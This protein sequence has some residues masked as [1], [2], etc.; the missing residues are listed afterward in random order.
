MTKAFRRPTRNEVD[1]INRLQQERFDQSYRLFEPPLP[2]GVPGRLERIV[3][4]A[5]IR[6]D[7][8]VLD[9]GSGTGILI[10]LIQKYHPRKIIA[11]DLSKEMLGQLKKNYTGVEIIQKDIKDLALPDASIDV[12]FINACY[13]NIAD[14]E[15]AFAN[16]GRMLKESGRLTISHPLG[17]SF[18]DRLRPGAPY[19]LDNFPSKTEAS[20]LFHP[21]GFKVKAYVDEPKLYILTLLKNQLNYSNSK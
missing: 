4:A 15:G 17:K 13:P 10:P 20:D 7:D 16:L 2:E 1:R 3:A 19:P 8:R 14:K 21:Y 9:V 12:V 18:V 5:G 11:C 6:G